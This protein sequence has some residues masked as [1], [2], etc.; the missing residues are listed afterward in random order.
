MTDQLWCAEL[1]G[2]CPH[3]RHLNEIPH[4]ASCRS[5]I[6]KACSCALREAFLHE[7]R[8]AGRRG[9]G[10]RAPGYKYM[11]SYDY[12]LHSPVEGAP[13]QMNV[14]GPCCVYCPPRRASM[15][16][17]QENSP[18]FSPRRRCLKIKRTRLESLLDARRGRP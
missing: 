18:R 17:D 2:W 4:A 10:Q 6:S 13:P 5:T 11:V 15:F 14:R 7:Q 9:G 8:V 1:S 3:R 16:K 12:D